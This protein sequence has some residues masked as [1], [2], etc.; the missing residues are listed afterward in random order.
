MEEQHII[1]SKIKTLKTI[2][3]IVMLV[4]IIILTY[5]IYDFFSNEINPILVVILS[6]LVSSMLI[7]SQL[8]KVQE[9]KLSEL[10]HKDE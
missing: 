8:K 10:D 9:N 6:L 2:L 5:T 1:K 3:Y 4:W 7:I